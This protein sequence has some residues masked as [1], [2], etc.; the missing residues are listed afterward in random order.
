MSDD[1]P[2]KIRQAVK[3]RSGGICEACGADRGEHVHHRK[4]RSQGGKHELVNLLHV[5]TRCHGLIHH[6]PTDSYIRG[7]LVKR[8]GDPE[9]TPVI[10]FET[11]DA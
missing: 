10:K 7:L 2:P 5:S 4:L 8:A 6:N 9:S 1:I 3:E 11:A